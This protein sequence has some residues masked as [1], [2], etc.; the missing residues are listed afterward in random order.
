MQWW[1]SASTCH[2]YASQ[3]PAC[4]PS[5]YQDTSPAAQQEYFGAV[6][7]GRA[8][9][10]F[11]RST[12]D[13]GNSFIKS[14]MSLA[15]Q[16]AP[17]I[18][19]LKVPCTILALSN[20]NSSNSVYLCLPGLGKWCGFITAWHQPSVHR[21]PHREERR[22]KAKAQTNKIVAA[23]T[24]VFCKDFSKAMKGHVKLFPAEVM[25]TGVQYSRFWPGAWFRLGCSGISCN[26]CM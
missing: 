19:A 1:F 5:A 12:G 18:L 3:L 10:S 22:Q 23:H 21:G 25:C 9:F 17:W 6:H 7:S 26:C 24:G 2:W 8:S 13:I 14:T 15:G 20:R 4:L 16:N 11:P